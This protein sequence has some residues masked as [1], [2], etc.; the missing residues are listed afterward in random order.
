MSRPIR[1]T[2]TVGGMSSVPRELRTLS[3]WARI[4]SRVMVR[5]ALS[6]SPRSEGDE[7]QTERRGRSESCSGRCVE[8]VERSG[9][10]QTA[11]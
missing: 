10:P 3:A 2:S 1:S 6:D 7:S 5:G 8:D 9:D 4:C 11:A